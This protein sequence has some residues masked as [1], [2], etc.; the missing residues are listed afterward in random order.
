MAGD[1]GA[2][3]PELADLQNALQPFVKTRAETARISIDF[4]AQI[5]S[6]LKDNASQLSAV[7]LLRQEADPDEPI[8]PSITG[9]RRAYLKALQAHSAA[10]ARY[11]ALKTELAQLSQQTTT[12]RNLN[13]EQRN[14]LTESYL[15][16]LRQ[17]ERSRKLQVVDRAL[18]AIDDAGKSSILMHVDDLVKQHAGELPRPPVKQASSFDDRAD[19]D[20]RI[21]QLKRAILTMKRAIESHRR[22]TPASLNGSAS[23]DPVG[24]LQ[25][26]L[27][28]LTGWMETQLAIIGDGQQESSNGDAS[29]TNGHHDSPQPSLNDI[30]QLYDDY[31]L[32]RQSLL[33]TV[34]NPP[35]VSAAT[36]SPPS[37]SNP[38]AGP[39]QTAASHKSPAKTVLPYLDSLMFAKQEEGSLLQQSAYLR[40][41]IAASEAETRRMIAR[42][43]D[44]S[45][46]VQPGASTSKDW[47]KAAAEAGKRT[48][49]FVEQRMEAGTKSV[50]EAEKVLAGVEKMPELLAT[51]AKVD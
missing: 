23:E 7:T 37:T 25:S 48:A 31:V 21:L 11:D 49:A 50:R 34:T 18:S 27:N 42:L 14:E 44:E 1:D 47:A 20:G 9:V 30:Q 43:A 40:R 16:M 17:R 38:A 19:V 6:H 3:H 32:A 22:E 8:A 45:H 36:S 24:G 35:H 28:E 12:D 41:Q 5:Q 51:V 15:P 26:A 46:L 13:G 10:Q 39:M 2:S 29:L 33:H 4:Q